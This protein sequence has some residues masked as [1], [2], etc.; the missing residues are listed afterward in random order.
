MSKYRCLASGRLCR[1]VDAAMPAPHLRGQRPRLNRWQS[2]RQRGARTRRRLDP[3][4]RA[5]VRVFDEACEKTI[6]IV[7]VS[8]CNVAFECA[9]CT[10]MIR[11]RAERLGLDVTRRAP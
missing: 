10:F 4:D 8:R 1:P 3:V 11:I 9:S 2:S 7:A 6:T 5:K